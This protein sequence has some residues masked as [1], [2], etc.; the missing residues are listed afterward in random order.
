[1][2]AVV[3]PVPG[4][5]TRPSNLPGITTSGDHAQEGYVV[6]LAALE[7]ASPPATQRLQV[8]AWL[9]ALC[10]DDPSTLILTPIDH[11]YG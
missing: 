2:A 7:D 8:Q 10:T 5:V 9:S 1:M 6:G 3:S 11:R 4:L